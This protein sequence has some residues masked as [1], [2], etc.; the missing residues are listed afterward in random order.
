MLEGCL[1]LDLTN[2]HGFIC[3]RILADLGAEVIKIEPP[4]G[5]PARAIGPFYHCTHDK[6]SSLQWIASNT[7]VKSITLD[8]EK[9]DGKRI[10]GQLAGKADFLLESFAPGFMDS[11]GIGYTTLAETNPGIIMT[12]ITPFGQTGPYRSWK[13]ADIT[14]QAMSGIM[15]ITGPQDRPPLKMGLEPSYYLASTFAVMGTL[16]ALH[17]RE[18]SG[19]GQHVDLSMY[20]CMVSANFREPVRWEFEKRVVERQGNRLARGRASG[21]LVWPCR[22]G[23]VTWFIYG[24]E[25]GARE[26]YAL[27][28]W[29]STEGMAG[30][31]IDIK[32]ETLH[33][34]C[35][36]VQQMDIF[37]RQIARFFADHTKKEL[38]TGAMERGIRLAAVNTVQDVV[39]S[40]H[41]Q[42]RDFWIDLEHTNIKDTIRSPGAFFRSTEVNTSPQR[43]APFIGEHNEEVYVN[44]LGFSHREMQ[45]LHAS[46]VI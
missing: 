28:D 4:E 2:A 26:A 9:V 20:E 35:L 36:T 1:G 5:A 16:V 21:R 12:S 42:S 11:A 44:R 23:Y 14:I 15:S 40:E 39:N 6:E 32:W 3:G 10:L 31:L 41:L 33:I 8:I 38:E 43:G 24:G 45:T 18:L 25:L 27:V 30:S 7:G 22:D 13:A 34:S 29:M 46:R 17:Y 37:E 19:E